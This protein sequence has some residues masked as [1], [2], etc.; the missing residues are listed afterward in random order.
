MDYE[1]TET[2]PRHVHTHLAKIIMQEEALI[3]EIPH[4]A[5]CFFPPNHKTKCGGKGLITMLTDTIMTP[6][7]EKVLELLIAATMQSNICF[8]FASHLLK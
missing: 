7:R 5:I 4:S 3:V 6:R 8:N 2:S 1:T